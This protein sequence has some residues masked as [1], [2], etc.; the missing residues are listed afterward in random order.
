MQSEDATC[1]GRLL[2]VAVLAETE[3]GAVLHCEQEDERRVARVGVLVDVVEVALLR[4]VA[5]LLLIAALRG[6]RLDVIPWGR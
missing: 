4:L 5:V 1:V 6:A 3:A 2:L